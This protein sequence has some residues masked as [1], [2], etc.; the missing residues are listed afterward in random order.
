MEATALLQLFLLFCPTFQ[1]H[2]KV[3]PN[4]SQFSK[5]DPVSL[6]CEG[7]GH[8]AVVRNTSRRSR[9]RCGRDWGQ[10]K[11]SVCTIGA[12]IPDDSGLY[13]CEGDGHRS[14][15]LH[16]NVRR[17]STPLTDVSHLLYSRSPSPSAKASPPSS[18]PS[19]SSAEPSPPSQR[20]LGVALLS[21]LL[22]LCPYVVSTV[23]MLSLCRH[24][25]SEDSPPPLRNS[26][27]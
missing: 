1:A 22:V 16:I 27:L 23:L 11:A 20:H 5:Y 12:L 21:H 6:R 2:M 3:S 8:W 18:E 7:P 10:F 26:N 13:W 15:P 4:Q 19:P 14:A 9:Q 17:E 24:T 25:R